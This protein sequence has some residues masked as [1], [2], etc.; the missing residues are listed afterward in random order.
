M[1]TPKS[2]DIVAGVVRTYAFAYNNLCGSQVESD[3]AR[4]HLY[5]HWSS[6]SIFISGKPCIPY[7]II[8]FYVN[9]TNSEIST[10]YACSPS[11]NLKVSA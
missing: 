8:R 9:N 11:I 6:I 4:R 1:A 10:N 7:K 3:E 5:C 2:K